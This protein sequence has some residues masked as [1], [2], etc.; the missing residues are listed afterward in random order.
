MDPMREQGIKAARFEIR[1]TC[2]PFVGMLSPQVVR[3]MYFSRYGGPGSQITD[4]AWL[5][6]VNK[7]GLGE[8]LRKVAIHRAGKAPWR[9][10]LGLVQHACFAEV[11]LLDDEWLLT[12]RVTLAELDPGVS[13]VDQAA[14]AGDALDL[15]RLLGQNRFSQKELDQGLFSALAGSW[16][17][18]GVVRLL[19]A[20]GANVNARSTDGSTPL[21]DASANNEI[22][23]VRI[24]LIAGANP[25]AV[26]SSGETALSLAACRRCPDSFRAKKEY[27]QELVSLLT[28]YVAHEVPS[29][30]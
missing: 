5:G 26:N 4:S 9:Y 7:A 14:W 28:S 27:S 20:A 15:E 12:D 10:S 24:L 17:A 29:P 30:D 23:V 11:Y 18:T 8:A 3:E 19:I 6:R 2:Y 25:N 22:D 16:D 1:G 21:L 13:A